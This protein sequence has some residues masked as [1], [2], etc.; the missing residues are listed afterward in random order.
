MRYKIVE[1]VLDVNSNIYGTQDFIATDDIKGKELL[2]FCVLTYEKS[3]Q[4]CYGIQYLSRNSCKNSKQIFFYE[5]KARAILSVE[6]DNWTKF[7]IHI[8][9]GQKNT[10]QE[11]ILIGFYSYMSFHQT[12][13]L[14]ASAIDYNGKSVVFTAPSGTGKTTQAELWM[15]YRG[16]KILNGDKVFLKQEA[17]AIHAWGSPWTGSS[18]YGLNSSAPLEAII[19]LKQAKENS[20]RRLDI[21][22]AMAEFLPNV[23]F[24]RWDEQ[25]EQAVLDFLD[26][27]MSETKFYLLSC[28]PDEEA[29]EITE[30]A[31]FGDGLRKEG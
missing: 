4:C 25:C 14:H 21:L 3:V 28:R 15:K 20:I 6:N 8:H 10:L 9:E 17:D 1:T 18:P 22:E 7:N 5:H 13:L 23:F 2:I 16:A 30:K 11:L 24:P 26:K 12:L 19:I 27:V 31:I 29:V